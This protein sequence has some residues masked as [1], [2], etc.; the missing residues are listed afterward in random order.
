MINGKSIFLLIPKNEIS[1]IYN[2]K[3]SPKK[4][5]K[6]EKKKKNSEKTRGWFNQ[7]RGFEV[8]KAS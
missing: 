2:D 4:K 3:K 1:T 7:R 8:D 6:S 5:K